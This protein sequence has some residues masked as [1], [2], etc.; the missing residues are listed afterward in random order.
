[1]PYPPELSALPVLP[2]ITPS[3]RQAV[4]TYIGNFGNTGPSPT[5]WP[6][7]NRAIFVPFVVPGP[8]TAKALFVVNDFTIGGNLDLGIY[9]QD[10]NRLVSTGSFASSVTWH[11]VTIPDTLLTPG[12]SYYYLATCRS[13]TQNTNAYV[14]GGLWRCRLA[15]LAKADLGSVTLPASVTLAAPSDDYIPN[16]GILTQPISL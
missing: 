8:V 15:G 1:M 12:P 6:A 5:T 3:H 9:D 2:S 14:L 11:V 7:A 10:G 13:A 16:A 4:G